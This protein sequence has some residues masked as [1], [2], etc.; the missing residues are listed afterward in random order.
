MSRA[1]LNSF[2]LYEERDSSDFEK[3]ITMLN[4]SVREKK[5]FRTRQNFLIGNKEFV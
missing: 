2:L 4:V 5:N 1:V 3:Q